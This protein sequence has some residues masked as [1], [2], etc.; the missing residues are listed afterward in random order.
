MW[1]DWN[2]NCWTYSAVM[3]TILDGF[4]I[5]MCMEED[6][7]E[8]IIQSVSLWRTF[9]NWLTIVNLNVRFHFVKAQ[10]WWQI[11][12]K[13]TI[14]FD[15][16]WLPRYWISQ[17]INRKN[18]LLKFFGTNQLFLTIC[19]YQFTANWLILISNQQCQISNFH[20]TARVKTISDRSCL[21]EPLSASWRTEK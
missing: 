15:A 6:A 13:V 21:A 9:Q 3:T 14:L 16:I 17:I 5:Y 10:V 12:F 11:H 20:T 1:S 8:L 7:I 4:T 18:N 2:R 19:H